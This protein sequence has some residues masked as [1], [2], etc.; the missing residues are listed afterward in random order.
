MKIPTLSDLARVTHLLH[1][2][3]A[4]SSALKSSETWDGPHDKSP[5]PR[6]ARPGLLQDNALYRKSERSEA[7]LVGTN[8]FSE[9]RLIRP[10]SA[11]YA[12]SASALYG[13][14]RELR[15][16]GPDSA[17]DD[18]L[19]ARAGIQLVGGRDLRGARQL[20][21]GRWRAACPGDSVRRLSTG[22][23]CFSLPSDG[24]LKQPHPQISAT[25]V[26]RGRLHRRR[27]WHGLPRRQRYDS[28]NPRLRSRG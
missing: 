27:Q 20:T 19:R 8:R 24:R 16:Q 12:E 28:R 22:G 11:R 1:R 17:G 15:F 25:D 3:N 26:W 9:S 2:E 6:S 10:I 14:R 13:E 18:L 5:S 23:V 7:D 4:A 21:G